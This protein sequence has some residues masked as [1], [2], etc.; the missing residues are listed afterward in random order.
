MFG[1]AVFGVGFL[2]LGPATFLTFLP[3]K[4]V[5]NSNY[6][7]IWYSCCVFSLDKDCSYILEISAL[8]GKGTCNLRAINQ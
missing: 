8:D 6:Y 5:T 7:I 3:A 1:F 2:V 4:Y